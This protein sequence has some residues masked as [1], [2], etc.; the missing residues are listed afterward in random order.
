MLAG[1]IHASAVS[2]EVSRETA[3]LCSSHRWDGWLA[4]LLL[5]GAGQR[6]R[7]AQ[8]R[9]I[10]SLL[11]PRFGIGTPLLPYLAIFGQ[12]S[13]NSSPDS[14]WG[15]KLYLLVG[16]LKVKRQGGLV[17]WRGIMVAIFTNNS[18]QK[19]EKATIP[20]QEESLVGS[21][22]DLSS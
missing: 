6:S 16:D 12:T 1:L 19:A 22:E 18:P 13:H 4:W 10:Q 20:T 5:M 11:R 14:N 9:N 15:K 7:G 21:D 8:G 17:T 3:D 2:G